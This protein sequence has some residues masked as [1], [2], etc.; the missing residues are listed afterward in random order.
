MLIYDH[1][2]TFADAAAFAAA[3]LE[4]DAGRPVVV[5]TERLDQ[6][7]LFPFEL[8]GVL[9]YV[10]RHDDADWTPEAELEQLAQD[11][12]GRFAGT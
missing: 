7:T 12:G 6:V 1:F 9:V 4:R 2:E 5:S 3:V 10:D 8:A 11:A